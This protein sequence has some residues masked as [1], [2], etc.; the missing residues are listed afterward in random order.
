M[1]RYGSEFRM[2]FLVRFIELAIAASLGITLNGA[3]A[4][5]PQ[6]NPSPEAK[7]E[8]IERFFA[9]AEMV[10]APK[11][12]DCT[13]SGGTKTTCFSIT[14]KGLPSTYKPGPWC[15]ANATDGPEAS[16]IWLHR[17]EVVEADGAFMANLS[18]FYN[19]RN[20]RVVDPATGKVNVTDTLQGCRAA[21]NPNPDPAYKNYCVQCL[22]EYRPSDATTTYVIPVVQQRVWFGKST[23]RIGAGVAYNGVRLDG[24]APIEIILGAYTI[25]PFDDCGGHVNP[26]VGYHYHAV[27]DCLNS[28]A[29]ASA[30]GKQIG[31][32]LD[33]Y[34]IFARASGD[35]SGRRGL[36]RC[37]GHEVDDLGYHYHA[38]APGSNAIIG[39]FSAE[40]GCSLDS[41]NDTCNASIPRRPPP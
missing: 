32:A 12:V 15:P 30:H 34:A 35:E 4:Q 25:A 31:I 1:Q 6:I 3:W 8:T 38:G 27:T 14:V 17:G 21:A 7:L 9:T 26:H 2:R 41:P 11:I 36:D 39:C 16:G 28:A 40:Y 19:D 20:W 29:P 23:N 22:P 33:G 10:S 24:P 5:S 37:N 18:K 13:L